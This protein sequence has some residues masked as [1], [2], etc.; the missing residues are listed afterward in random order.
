MFIQIL[1]SLKIKN[2]AEEW[3][4]AW[5]TSSPKNFQSNGMVERLIA[6]IKKMFLKLD[7]DPGKDL[8]L[9]LLEYRN[10]P[11]DKDLKSPN[12]IMFW[13]KIRG[14][15]PFKIN[16]SLKKDH[17]SIKKKFLQK[18]ISQKSYFDKNT[19]NLKPLNVRDQVYVRK[20]LNKPLIPAKIIDKCDRPRSYKVKLE[21]NREIERNRKHIFGPINN[22]KIKST[23]LNNEQTVHSNNQIDVNRKISVTESH[24]YDRIRLQNDNNNQN[25]E[26]N[27]EKTVENDNSN[28]GTKTHNETNDLE[29][30]SN[31]T[32]LQNS[33]AR[34]NDVE[35]ISRSGRLIKTPKYLQDYIRK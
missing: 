1:N 13:R 9:A 11:I 2:F 35:K 27:I 20:D 6:T 16:E 24:V 32:S 21:N 28:E 30:I 3:G 8:A 23:L 15:L 29:F 7:K 12:E 33:N 18:Q 5:R 14:L 34:D 31:N 10:M 25:T 19:H 17:E 22:N 4:F 26:L